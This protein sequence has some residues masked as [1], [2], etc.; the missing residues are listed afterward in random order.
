MQN[1]KLRMAIRATAAVAAFGMAGQALALDVP[2]GDWDTSI[3]GYARLNAAY[4]ID[5]NHTN[6]AQTGSFDDINT[7]DAEDDEVSGHFDADA[8]QTRI[9]IK[10]I[11]PEGVKMVVEGDFRG[12]GGGDLRL[13]HAYGEY[14]GVL[15]GQ[16]W[17]NFNSFVGNTATLDFDSLPGSAGLQGRTAQLRYTM[18][19]FSVSAEEPKSNLV[20]V[21]TGPKTDD[22][23]TPNDYTDDTTVNE[24][25]FKEQKG[26]Q[27][28][29]PTL[30]ARYEDSVGS[31]S[32]SAA[33]LVH[34]VG[35][36]DGK[37]NDD[38]AM[39]Y[40]A[41]AAVKFAITDMIDI[42]GAFS[43]SDG[44]NSYL[45]RSGEDYNG[46]DAYVTPQ[47]D[48]ETIKAYSGTIGTGIKLGSG[49]SINVGY[50]MTTMDW[51]DAKKDY[52]SVGTDALGV[53]TGTAESN[54]ALMANYKFSP[55]KNVMM[56]V[57]YQYLKT[58]DVDGDEGDSNRLLFAAQYNF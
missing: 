29:M 38:S 57:E 7:G 5:E 58:E 40:G 24:W 52:A 54:S 42:H 44:A 33:A 20:K 51:D 39:G 32:Y 10:T 6:S 19:G 2:T 37:T 26:K 13:R 45:W 34:Q 11:T 30:T 16:T 12:N 50:G 4:D 49:S 3:Y 43:Y 14:N 35:Y 23:D 55:V 28:G 18:G 48:V 17:S 25:L 46:A 21:T 53:I 31:L 56:G 8:V 1:N 22:N 47:G 41:F 9:G 27:D 36:D 15:A